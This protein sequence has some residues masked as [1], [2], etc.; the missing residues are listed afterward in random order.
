[1]GESLF[2][3][4]GEGLKRGKIVNSPAPV[5]GEGVLAIDPEEGNDLSEKRQLEPGGP[6]EIERV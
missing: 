4:A 6:R 3:V 2:K 5:R 1:M